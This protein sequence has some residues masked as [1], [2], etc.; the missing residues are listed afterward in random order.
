M[1]NSKS[2]TLDGESKEPSRCGQGWG[3]ALE[4]EG[5]NDHLLSAGA[6]C[7]HQLHDLS[8]PPMSGCLALVS[9]A[10]YS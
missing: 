1:T 7:C 6:Q 3:D 8:L 5:V 2:A 4:S 9:T 10:A